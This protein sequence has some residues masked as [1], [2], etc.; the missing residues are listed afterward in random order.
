MMRIDIQAE[1]I[2]SFQNEK[3]EKYLH[4]LSHQRG[5]AKGQQ[6]LLDRIL[7]ATGQSL[8]L[9]GQRL[10]RAAGTHRAVEQ[11]RPVLREAI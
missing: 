11:E 3:R 4:G 10:Q 9:T 8:I 5:Q 6:S 2:L 7:D 1:H